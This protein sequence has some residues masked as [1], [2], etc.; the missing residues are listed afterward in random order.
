MIDNIGLVSIVIVI[1]MYLKC[2]VIDVVYIYY[3]L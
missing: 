2:S 1:K 3:N